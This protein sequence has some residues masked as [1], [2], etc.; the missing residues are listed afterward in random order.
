MVD[1]QVPHFPNQDTYI[2][3]AEGAEVRE[4]KRQRAGRGHAG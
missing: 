1:Y 2:Y 3:F 4:R